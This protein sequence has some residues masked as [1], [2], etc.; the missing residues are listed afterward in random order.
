MQGTNHILLV[1]DQ[2]EG[3][4]GIVRTLKEV[5]AEREVRVIFDQEQAL[6]IIGLEQSELVF[7]YLRCGALGATFFLN[8]VWKRNPRGA[9]FLLDQPADPQA[10]VRCILGA[11]YFIETPVNAEKVRQ[12][13]ARADATERFVRNDN[14]RSLVSK[15][16]TLPSKPSSY[17]EIMREI[18]S[19]TASPATVAELVAKD[20]AVSTKLVQLANS[21]FFGAGQPISAVQD[22]VLLLG[23]ENT[24][25]AVMGIE[26]FAKFDKVKPLYFSVEKVW[27]HSQIIADA[28]RKIAQHFSDDREFHSQ[29]YLAA[30]LHDIGKLTFSENFGDEYS[31]AVK[32]A[33]QA[34]RSVFELEQEL[35]RATHADTGAYL[36]ALW[37]LPISIVEA[38]ANHHNPPGSLGAEFT[39]A[40]ALH[41][42]EALVGSRVSAKEIIVRYPSEL[43]LRAHLDFLAELATSND[44]KLKQQRPNRTRSLALNTV[45]SGNTTVIPA[46]NEHEKGRFARLVHGL[47]HCVGN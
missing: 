28:A 9:R 39:P 25:S 16:R 21:G 27:K 2:A 36:L 35:F 20:L 24:A 34:G 22:A 8:E 41:L 15:M 44:L 12:A 6:D 43:G 5:A 14:I 30:L 33:E 10:L 31:N 42:A 4:E 17:L 26:A 18:R 40:V 45:S 19:A 11:H 1:S 38:V 46:R 29:V 47:L 32:T 13:I 23:L 37:G 3:L 7:C